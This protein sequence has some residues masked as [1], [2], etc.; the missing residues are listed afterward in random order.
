MELLAVAQS[1]R[2]LAQSASRGGLPCRAIDLYADADTYRYTCE[3]VAVAPGPGG[4]DER[5]LL[6]AAERLAPAGS[7]SGL[8]YGSG[9]DTRPRLVEALGQGRRLLGNLPRT[10]VRIKQPRAFFD[11]L[12]RLGVPFPETRHSPPTNRAGWLIKPCCG[13]G[14]KG[15]GFAE[16]FP[17]TENDY[18]QR[19]IRGEAHSALFLANGRR[20]GLIGLN[21]QWTARHDARQ[22][23]LFAGAVNR[24]ALTADQCAAVEDY[25]AR[26]TETLGLVGLNS[27]DFVVDGDSC[28][29]LEFNPRPSATMAL[30]D[31]EFPSG[32]IVEHIAAC[33]GEPLPALGRAHPIRAMRIAYAPNSLSVPADFLWP[34][35]CA[36]I[37]HPG[38]RIE[39]GQPLCS[40]LAES[41]SAKEAE[42]LLKNAERRLLEA[43]KSD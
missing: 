31:A 33:R 32:L 23:F 41:G 22:P 12:G 27:L 18:Y 26:L 38:A 37:P 5:E 36:D 21:T 11:L 17:G 13:E 30:Y 16:N 14:G 6:R 39:A 35:G 25:A 7:G 9:I 42:N 34:E 29:V 19:H 28:R 8:V 10:L 2:L 43:L 15:V 20:A 24:A 1:A 3:C 4:F 40:L